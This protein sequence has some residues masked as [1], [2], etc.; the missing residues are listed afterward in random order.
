MNSIWASWLLVDQ[1]RT[2]LFGDRPQ[3]AR[4][5]G[6]HAPSVPA[7]DNPSSSERAPGATQT[8]TDHV[9]DKVHNGV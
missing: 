2:R 6:D 8:T 1:Q 9:F 5:Y 7:R 3:Q 4:A